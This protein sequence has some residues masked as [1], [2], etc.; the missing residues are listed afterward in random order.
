MDRRKFVGLAAS[1]LIVLPVA[2]KGQPAPQVRR[3]GWVFDLAPMSATDFYEYTKHLRA[4][5]WIEGKNLVIE[6]RYTSGN[7]NLL[8]AFAEEL[9]R[10]KVDLIVA[11]GTLAA[12]AGKKATTTIPIVF[13]RAADPVRVGLVASLAHP[14]GNITGTST[15]EPDLDRKRIQILHELLPEARRIGLL[16]VPTDPTEL[17]RRETY[18][19]FAP[20]F[21]LQPI[22]VE[23]TQAGD[24]E[25]AVAEAARRGS[26]VLHIS[27]QPLLAADENFPRILRAAQKHSLPIM[28]D[29]R[30]W[31]EA[32][33]LIS[34]GPDNDELERQLAV[35]IDKVLR[36]A[37]PSDVPV[38]QPR[39]IELGINL[40]A[41][42]S[43]GIAVPQ[44]LLMRANVVVR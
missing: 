35:V 1:S 12:L 6:Q 22:F 27:P 32:G 42:K 11:H 44:S 15:M 16:L 9:V 18:E 29:N 40:K 30:G 41:A 2:A 23:V 37:N 39:N 20:S 31:L 33:A 17:W 36:G 4:K 24:L 25:N 19:A 43:F 8:P 38:M 10:L 13:G 34:C 21:G 28:F 5:G 26:Q 7:A 3:I 14:G